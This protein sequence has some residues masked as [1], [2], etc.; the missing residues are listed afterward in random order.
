MTSIEEL[1]PS[2]R[3]TCP[4]CGYETISDSYEIC[5][6]CA[7]EYD[8]SQLRNPDEGGGPNPMTLREA[9]RNYASFGAKGERYL[10]MVRAPTAADRRDPQ[11]KPL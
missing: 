3:V 5:E 8:E 6:I 9:Q 10:D 1:T 2:R 11:W 7:W 4:C